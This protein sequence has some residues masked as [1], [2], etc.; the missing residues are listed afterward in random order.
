MK[1]FLSS[2][3]ATVMVLSSAATVF[4]DTNNVPE[5]VNISVKEIEKELYEEGYTVNSAMDKYIEN[6][7]IE[8]TKLSD[9]EEIEKVQNL[10]DSAEKLT[11]QYNAKASSDSKAVAAIVA[12]F[13]ANEYYLSAELL[14][15]A[16]SNKKL[17]SEYIPYYRYRVHDSD[18]IAKIRK[19]SAVKGSSSFNEGP[20]SLE[21][22]LHFAIN[23]FTWTKSK[24]VITI[25]DRY[26]F[27]PGDYDGIA[28]TAVNAMWWAQEHGVLTPFYT[29]IQTS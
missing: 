2:L 4:A 12:Y 11:M 25:R 6:L 20:T 19:S 22:D 29:V 13:G 24:G 21:M 7:N 3:L 18:V 28:E 23:L 15:H 9:V 14:S 17:D 16:E 1:R 26:D 10:I 8:K 5:E 27:K